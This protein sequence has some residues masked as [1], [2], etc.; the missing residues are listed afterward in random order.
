MCKLVKSLYGLKQAPKQWHE[1]FDHVIL[2]HG[3]RHKKCGQ[4]LMRIVY[5]HFFFSMFCLVFSSFMI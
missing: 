4:V 1:N 3:F 2:S 5:T